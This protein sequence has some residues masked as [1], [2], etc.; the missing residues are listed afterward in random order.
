MN[1]NPEQMLSRKLH[2][3]ADDHVPP[4]PPMLDLL[5]AGRRRR[6]HRTIRI[7]VAAAAAVAAVAAAAGLTR[8]QVTDRPEAPAT[9]TH[10][11]HQRSHR[12]SNAPPPKFTTLATSVNPGGALSFASD[13]YGWQV[14]GLGGEPHQDERLAAG[15]AG[16]TYAWPGD[17]LLV[18]TD[19]GVSWRP[20]L[21]GT[22]ADN[23]GIWGFDLLSATEGWVVGVTSLH[24]T[25]DGGRTWQTLAEPAGRYLVTVDFTTARDG[26]GLT[27]GGAL[28]AT[29]DGGRTWTDA[30]LGQPATALCATGSRAYAVGQSGQ[31]YAS[32]DSGA[33]WQPTGPSPAARVATWAQLTCHGTH[34]WAALQPLTMR[35]HVSLGQDYQ[36]LSTSD[37]GTTWRSETAS[38]H[39]RAATGAPAAVASSALSA[40]DTPPLLL[41]YGTHEWAVRPWTLDGGLREL[42]P[43]RG[44]PHGT[45]DSDRQPYLL[46][47]GAAQV[48]DH[49]WVLVA[50][51][52]AGSVEAP[53]SQTLLAYSPDRGATWQVRSPSPGQ[54]GAPRN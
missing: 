6:R 11:G 23:N 40:D 51:L 24:A 37:A 18:T 25:T 5:A 47:P 15:P 1:E 28:V 26:L 44:L 50:D 22:G 7:A 14:G 27:T 45:P 53:K 33:S 31:L 4:A 12:T 42:T 52:A 8:S 2:D 36:V 41:G 9:H 46:V 3:L 39:G 17:S 29:R 49:V 21:D 20:V 19:G 54:P 43:L 32:A 35:N 30:R 10:G 34:A 13:S 16:T 48:G 38:D